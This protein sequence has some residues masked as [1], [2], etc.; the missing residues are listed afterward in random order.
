M[1]QEFTDDFRMD[2]LLQ[3]QCGGRMAQVVKADLGKPCFVEQWPE[4]PAQE[5]PR[6]HRLP[7]LIRKD[8]VVIFP[9]LPATEP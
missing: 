4:G 7:D 6:F 2:T 9:R 3:E 8:Q 1:P 5:I